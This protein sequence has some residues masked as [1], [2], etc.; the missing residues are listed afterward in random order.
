M[1]TLTIVPREKLWHHLQMTHENSESHI[2]EI[3]ARG[4]IVLPAAVRRS[5]GLETGQKLFLTVE[6]AGSLRLT[7]ARAVAQAARGLF[8]APAPERSLVDELIAERRAEGERE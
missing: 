6:G 5:L 3:G 7:T 8:K 4:R 1:A 2:L